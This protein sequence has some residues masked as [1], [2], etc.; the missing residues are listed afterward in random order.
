MLADGSTQQIDYYE[1]ELEWEPGWQ[2]VLAMPVGPES[3]LRMR[4]L[5]GHRL[6][7]EGSP[8]GDVEIVPGP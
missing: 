4:L 3:L 6:V 1:T 5:S 7:I 2:T 8:G